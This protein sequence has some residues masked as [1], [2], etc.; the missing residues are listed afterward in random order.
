MKIAQVIEHNNGSFSF[1]NHL[2]NEAARLVPDLFL[3]LK[4]VLYKIKV[5]VIQLS[6]NILW[7]F[8]T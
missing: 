1:K 6:F 4:N 5:S 2:Q 8:L 3:F 7:W